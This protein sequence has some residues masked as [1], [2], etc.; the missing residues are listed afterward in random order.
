MLQRPPAPAP[1]VR[2]PLRGPYPGPYPGRLPTRPPAVLPGLGTVPGSDAGGGEHP[3]G[4]RS[5]GADVLPGNGDHLGGRR[6]TETGDVTTAVR[7]LGVLL[8]DDH[9][10]VLDGLSALVSGAPDLTLVDAVLSAER[11]KVVVAHHR[12]DVVVL[13]QSLP[14]KS[15][16][17][18]CRE[19]TEQHA[20]AAVLMLTSSADEQTVQQAF[21]AGA[22][23]FLIKDVP[24]TTILAGIRAVGRGEVYVDPRIVG[25]LVGRFREP[26]RP[27]LAVTP[28]ELQ[29]VRAIA[30][31]L[32]NTEIAAELCVSES[33]AKS[34]VSRLKT[35]LGVSNRPALIAEA[36]RLGWL[37]RTN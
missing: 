37:T 35:R 3:R 25:S 6:V 5:G 31:G 13:D 21:E 10:V 28:R 23:G 19:L 14:G 34:Y 2:P 9:P 24:A 8:V 1:G 15:G 18:L 17:D 12:V 27:T 4:N 11:A 7:A 36:A 22:R 16:I 29:L 26:A 30:R 33:S 32:S 20:D